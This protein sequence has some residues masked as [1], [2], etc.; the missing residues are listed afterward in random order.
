MTLSQ[1]SHLHPLK[2]PE[3]QSFTKGFLVFSGGKNEIIDQKWVQSDLSL[4]C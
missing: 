2:T 4:S 1:Y 3:N